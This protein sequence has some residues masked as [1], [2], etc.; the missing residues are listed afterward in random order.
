MSIAINQVNSALRRLLTMASPVLPPSSHAMQALT[1]A[2][3]YEHPTAGW[4]DL[5]RE[6][7]Q[8]R[9][10]TSGPARWMALAE[11][12]ILDVLMLNTGSP[13]DQETSLAAFLR[14]AAYAARDIAQATNGQMADGDAAYDA[15]RAAQTADLVVK[16]SPRRA[17]PPPH[18]DTDD[19]G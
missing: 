14:A 16:K 18:E 9:S 17:P 7:A 15:E 2:V 6:D 19:W 12:S 4:L 10:D 1:D 5:W 8:T 11:H 3:H 13:E